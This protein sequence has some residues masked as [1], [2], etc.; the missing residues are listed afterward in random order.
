MLEIF[1]KSHDPGSRPWSRQYI[2]AIFFHNGEQKNLAFESLKQEEARTHA[3]IFTEIT[4]AGRFYPAENYHQ[5]Y[6]LRQRPDIMNELKK[7]YPDE[8]F[9]DSTVA[10]RINGFLA[11]SGSYAAL[12]AELGAL[13]SPDENMHLLDTVTGLRR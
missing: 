4:P 5:K 11:G 9:V 10:A 1:W 8:T 3:K 2:S 12:K 6:Y 13:L 7:I